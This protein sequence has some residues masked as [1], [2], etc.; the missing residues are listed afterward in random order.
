MSERKTSQAA[1]DDT[2][3]KASGQIDRAGIW[4]FSNEMV[5]V[6]DAN[7]IR[8]GWQPAPTAPAL[9]LTPNPT[10]QDYN[11]YPPSWDGVYDKGALHQES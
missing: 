7:G 2:I 6:Y 5:A 1:V 8:T 9:F 4:K 10:S 3:L 11:D